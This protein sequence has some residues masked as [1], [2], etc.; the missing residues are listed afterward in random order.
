MLLRSGEC[1]ELI[2]KFLNRWAL[3]M[4]VTRCNAGALS[5]VG[6][7]LSCRVIDSGILPWSRISSFAVDYVDYSFI[8]DPP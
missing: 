7:S 8:C 1:V 2:F 4:R 3:W 5:S 6:R